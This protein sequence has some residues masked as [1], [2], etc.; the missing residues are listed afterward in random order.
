M[1]YSRLRTFLLTFT[2]GIAVVSIYPRLAGYLDEIPVNLP[3]VESKTPIIIRV[4]PE[5]LPD[6]KSNKGY[7]EDG[8]LYF[9]KEKAINCSQDGGGGGSGGRESN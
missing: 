7:W 2:F 5:D 1:K 3:E 6:G 8:Y 9:S 4:C